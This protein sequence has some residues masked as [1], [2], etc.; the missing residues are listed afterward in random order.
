M[1]P[2]MV[3]ELRLMAAVER[4][5]AL[6]GEFLRARR[7]E[8]TPESV[9]LPRVGHPRRVR[10]L[11]REEVA[12]LASISSNYYTR[13]EQGKLPAPSEAVLGAIAH[14]LRLDTDQ[15]AYLRAVADRSGRRRLSGPSSQK[16]APE[17]LLLLENLERLPVLVVGRHMDILAW[18]RLAATLLTDFSALPARER[19]VVRLVF[20]NEEVRS[21]FKEWSSAART[22]ASLLRMGAA[23]N[24][25]DPRLVMLVSELSLRDHDFRRWWSAQRVVSGSHGR[26]TY[27]HP[28]AGEFELEWQ[29]LRTSV[30]PDQTIIAMTPPDSQSAEALHMLAR[31]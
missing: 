18:N 29:T 31:S 15:E 3:G 2:N 10:G 23:R 24:P 20:L 16:V 11:R 12:Q 30:H 27:V 6:L 17:I 26:R 22:G 4:E 7:E 8:I 28:A 25:D 14:A 19:N 13:L 21:R 9:G 1:T 5:R